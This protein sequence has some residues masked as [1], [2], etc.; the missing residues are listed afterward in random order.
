MSYVKPEKKLKLLLR[1]I[2]SALPLSFTLSCTNVVKKPDFKIITDQTD[3]SGTNNKTPAQP[4]LDDNKKI[5]ENSDNEAK[6]PIKQADKHF[7]DLNQLKMITPREIHQKTKTYNEAKSN[8]EKYLLDSA[9]DYVAENKYDYSTRDNDSKYFEHVKPLGEY[10]NI[11]NSKEQRTKFYNPR[12]PLWHNLEQKYLEKFSES[13]VN[14]LTAESIDI[15]EIIKTNPFGFLP[16]NLSQL[17]YYANFKSLG[18]LFNINGTKNVKA[19]FDDVKGQFDILI[20]DSNNNKHY[21]QIKNDGKINTSLKKNADFF[22]YIS[23]R[24]FELN[25]NQKV[26][27]DEFVESTRQWSKRLN[28]ARHSGTAWV[29]DRVKTTNTDYYELLIATNIHVFSLRNTFDKSLHMKDLKDTSFDGRWK[30]F[31]PGF[32]DGKNATD[33]SDNRNKSEYFRANRVQESIIGDDFGIFELSKFKYMNDNNKYVQAFDAY[34]QYLDAPYYIPRYKTEAYIKG[35]K[36]DLDN[37]PSNYTNFVTKN[38]GG[39]FLTLK[40]KIKK[41]KLKDVLPKLNEVIDTEVE[42]DWYINFNKDKFSPLKTQFY[43]GYSRFWNPFV[44][45]SPA[46][47]R[48]IKSTGGLISTQRRIIDEHIFRDVWLKY[49]AKLN[50]EY[51]SLNDRY[52]KYEKAFIDKE[53]GMPLTIVDQFSTLYTN[54]PFGELNLEEG[55]SGS[56]VI[57]SSF[58]VIG[59]LNTSVEDIPIGQKTLLP[60]PD[61]DF[62]RVI[63]RRTNGV[64]LFQ[65]LSD[66]YVNTKDNKPPFIFDGLIDKLKADKLQTVKLNPNSK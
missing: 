10:G 6:I 43:A 58:N 42:K 62:Q 21:F 26:W 60:L 54:I 47:F 51:N 32:Y 30:E 66:D 9:T 59:I 28:F 48:G 33:T 16:S 52:K 65:S 39:D 37:V 56:M 23:D 22:Q 38:S 53:H 27:V 61:T 19:T 15:N 44:K 46:Q 25:V 5:D 17:F 49:D 2:A 31:P 57:D 18:N 8:F 14:G 50:K 41:D 35:E 29:I 7:L 55:A 3:P 64:I 24:S 36:A 4:K 13:D 40:F 45:D 11:G 20:F 1:T 34:K 63:R 12:V